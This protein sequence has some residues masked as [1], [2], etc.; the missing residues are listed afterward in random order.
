MIKA[1]ASSFARERVLI[2][3]G[4]KY[5][6]V[7]KYGVDLTEMTETNRQKFLGADRKWYLMLEGLYRDHTEKKAND[8]QLALSQEFCLIITI[9]SNDNNKQVYTGITQKLNEYNFW[10]KNIDV[11]VTAKV[12]HM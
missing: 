2:Q 1:N 9:R 4:D 10:H 5:Y 12:S 3:Y 7:K 11:D 8:L 6:P